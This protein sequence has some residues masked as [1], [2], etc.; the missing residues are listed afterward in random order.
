MDN[1]QG[2][3][4]TEQAAASR[5]QSGRARVRARLLAPLDGLPRPKGASAADHA[6][7]IEHL[8]G[9]LAYMSEDALDGLAELILRQPGHRWPAL[10][11]VRSWAYAIEAPPPGVSDYA[12]SIIR[13]VMGRTAWDGGYA[14]ELLRH[15]RKAG[16][17]PGAYF[18]DKLRDEAHWNRRRLADLRAQREVGRCSEAEL[19]WL[20]AWHEDEALCRM[21]LGQG[22][23]DLGEEGAAA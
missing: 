10:G 6:K 19:R 14:V 5:T 15:A 9:K 21:I 12:T 1:V 4:N 13:S 18:I 8:V 2:A 11:L 17:P 16:P 7:D 20:A 3:E 23:M 22:E